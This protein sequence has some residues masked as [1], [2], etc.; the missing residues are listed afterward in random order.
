MSES[1]LRNEVIVNNKT[2][3]DTRDFDSDWWRSWHQELAA[4]SLMEWIETIVEAACLW[5]VS[6]AV[7]FDIGRECEIAASR[8]AVV[9]RTSDE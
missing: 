2:F 8:V 7:G 1:S 6:L 5:R 3:V 4:N 9:R